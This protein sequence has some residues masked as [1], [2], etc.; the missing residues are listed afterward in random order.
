[1]HFFSSTFSI[2]TIELAFPHI[3]KFLN[4]IKE[5]PSGNPGSAP[6]TYPQLTSDYKHAQP[7]HASVLRNSEKDNYTCTY[8]V[9]PRM[10]Q[11]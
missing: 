1:M 2:E 9:Q 4:D 11:H 10:L 5:P 3:P 8:L 6:V 7:A